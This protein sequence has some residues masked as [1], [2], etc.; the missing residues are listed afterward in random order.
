MI[1][2]AIKL[3]FWGFLGLM[4]LPSLVP[5]PETGA[6]ASASADMAETTVHAARFAGAMADEVGSVCSRQPALCDSGR[7]LA[8][9]ALARAHQGLV[10]ASDLIA[11]RRQDQEPS[12]AA[13]VD[14]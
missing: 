11:K 14:A 10:I 2:F 7:A 4:A 1:R 5:A 3:T 6:E 8:D 9:A 12:Q 13:E